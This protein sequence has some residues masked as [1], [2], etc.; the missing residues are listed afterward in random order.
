MK[1]KQLIFHARASL[2]ASKI[3]S[4]SIHC[5][6]NSLLFF[7]TALFFSLGMFAYNRIPHV[8]WIEVFKRM[9]DTCLSMEETV[10]RARRIAYELSGIKVD[11]P[12]NYTKWFVATQAYQ[13]PRTT[14]HVIVCCRK[15]AKSW[16]LAVSEV[17]RIFTRKAE[18]KSLAKPEKA[19]TELSKAPTTPNHIENKVLPSVT[20]FKRDCRTGLLLESLKAH[21][22]QGLLLHTWSGTLEWTTYGTMNVK[23][24]I[25]LRICFRLGKCLD[26]ESYGWKLDW[27]FGLNQEKEKYIFAAPNLVAAND[28]VSWHEKRLLDHAHIWSNNQIMTW[29]AMDG[30]IHTGNTYFA[31]VHIKALLD[32]EEE[33]RVYVTQLQE[34]MKLWQVCSSCSMTMESTEAI[35][36]CTDKCYRCHSLQDRNY[37]PLAHF[38]GPYTKEAVATMYPNKIWT[39]IGW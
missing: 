11:V 32:I 19:L 28:Y 14:L 27:G 7:L 24:P 3:K 37:A 16:D 17:T 9:M 33:I 1:T 22:S 31:R 29:G 13:S 39:K 36:I 18:R 38:F 15:R 6:N 2:S 23:I 10:A 4:H 5:L 30:F 8:T 35:L 26:P 25:P 34:D 21:K 12:R 20:H